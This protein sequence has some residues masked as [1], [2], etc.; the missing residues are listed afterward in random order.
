MVG[1]DLEL[2]ILDEFYSA[3]VLFV[4]LERFAILFCVLDELGIGFACGHVVGFDTIDLG[5]FVHQQ[6]IIMVIIN[7]T[8]TIIM[9]QRLLWE[10]WMKAVIF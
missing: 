2:K 6:S 7:I 1:G 9:I 3:L 4:I 5:Y 8:K 10:D